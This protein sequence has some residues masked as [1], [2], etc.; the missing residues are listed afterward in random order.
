MNGGLHNPA[1]EGQAERFPDD[2]EFVP[3][4]LT[5][6]Q[7]ARF[8]QVSPRTIKSLI[9]AEVIHPFRIGKENRFARYD[10]LEYIRQRTEEVRKWD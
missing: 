9:A 6:E 3:A 8:L 10:L 7:A 4:V 5:A 1:C 2:G